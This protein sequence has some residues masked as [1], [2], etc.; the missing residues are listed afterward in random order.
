MFHSFILMGHQSAGPE[1]LN[2]WILF[3]VLPPTPLYCETASCLYVRLQ[4]NC[5]HPSMMGI[6]L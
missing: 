4:N 5:F 3:R 1:S 6:D 2:G